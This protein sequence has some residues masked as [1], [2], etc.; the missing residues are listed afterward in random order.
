MDGQFSRQIFA[1][2]PLFLCGIF[3]IYLAAIDDSLFNIILDNVEQSRI[4][5]AIATVIAAAIPMFFAVGFIKKSLFPNWQTIYQYEEFI[6][7]NIFGVTTIIL[8]F[9]IAAIKIIEDGIHV[10]SIPVIVICIAFS[11]YL[12]KYTFDAKSRN[13]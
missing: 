10:M 1:S 3:L 8:L 11:I 7:K 5:V 12:I 13:Y 2:M 6:E 9:G 4:T